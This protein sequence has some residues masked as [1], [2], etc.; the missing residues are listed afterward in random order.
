M[1][2]FISKPAKTAQR[3][4]NSKRK[5]ANLQGRE[6]ESCRE[7]LGAAVVLRAHFYVCHY[8]LSGAL[9]SAYK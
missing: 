1:G 4:Y 9:N 6:F 8:V 2:R 7:D 3:E 5:S